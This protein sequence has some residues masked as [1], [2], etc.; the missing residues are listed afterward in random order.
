MSSPLSLTK[1]APKAPWT[2]VGKKIE[3]LTRKAVYDFDLL[4][5]QICQQSQMGKLKSKSQTAPQDPVKVAVALSGGKDSLTLLLMLKELSGR[6]F[7][8]LELFPIFVSGDYSCGAGITDSYLRGFC[9]DLGCSLEICETKQS[10]EGLECYSCSRKRRT[11]IF[12]KAKELGAEIIAFGHHRDDNAQ[13]LLLNLLHKAEPAGL[14][15]KVP[16]QRYGISIIRPLI[17]VSEQDIINFAKQSGFL[18]MTC[19]CPVGIHSKRKQIAKK[20]EELETLFP[21][22][23]QNL[24]RASLSW[25]LDKALHI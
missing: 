6:G 14:L 22:S 12:D 8:P 5:P 11:L 3:S 20:I 13:T 19:R 2:Q 24:S 23:S 18:R 7:P 16:M 1:T 4:D 15:P 9:S 25:G 17:Y 10:L 21:N